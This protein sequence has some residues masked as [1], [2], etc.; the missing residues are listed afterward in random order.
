MQLHTVAICDVTTFAACLGKL[1]LSNEDKCN[2]K[3]NTLTSAGTAA[4]L[5]QQV[6][7]APSTPTLNVCLD[8]ICIHQWCHDAGDVASRAEHKILYM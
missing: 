7:V 3:S 2:T 8:L 4:D 1:I 5:N 6:H